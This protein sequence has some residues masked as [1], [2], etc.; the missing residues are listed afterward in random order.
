M[1]DWLQGSAKGKPKTKGRS[2]S[3]I[4]ATRAAATVLARRGKPLHWADSCRKREHGR[5]HC[6]Q[7]LL[8]YAN[9]ILRLQCTSFKFFHCIVCRIFAVLCCLPPNH[10]EPTVQRS[11]RNCT[12]TPVGIPTQQPLWNL[13][14]YGYIGRTERIKTFNICHISSHIVSPSITEAFQY[15]KHLEALQYLKSFHTWNPSIVEALQ[16]LKPL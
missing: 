8:T 12:W 3:L 9:H 14:T 10:I 11:S 1:F 5:S 7:S 13:Q 4:L 15:L 6:P 2:Y 16:H